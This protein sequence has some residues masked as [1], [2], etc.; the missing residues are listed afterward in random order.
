MKYR[1]LS[2]TFLGDEFLQPWEE[3]HELVAL[4]IRDTQSDKGRRRSGG[5]PLQAL[6]QSILM[7]DNAKEFFGAETG[8]VEW[9]VHGTPSCITPAY[10]Q[11]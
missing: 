1:G 2:H 8:F 6:G 5:S 10:S 9:A 7:R 3:S 11:L 4:G